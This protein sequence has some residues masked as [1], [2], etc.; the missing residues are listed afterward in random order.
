MPLLG[1]TFDAALPQPAPPGWTRWLWP[2]W[3]RRIGGL[4][5]FDAAG[6][7]HTVPVT[8]WPLWGRDLWLAAAFRPSAP[9]L[10]RGFRALFTRLGRPTQS[11]DAGRSRG[12][13]VV[14]AIVAGYAGAHWF[15]LG[16]TRR[17]RRYLWLFPVALASVFLSLYDAIRFVWIDRA[18]FDRLVSADA[19]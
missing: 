4:I 6:T 17:G 14:L 3:R 2:D 12:M 11:F 9:P 15:Y 13:A 1:A 10:R 19:R 7:A 16:D 8:L 5:G 18:A